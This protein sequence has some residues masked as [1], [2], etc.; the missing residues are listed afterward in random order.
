MRAHH[1]KKVLKSNLSLEKQIHKLQGGVVQEGW[2]WSI[3]DFLLGRKTSLLFRNK[4][5]IR[6]KKMFL[7]F[8]KNTLN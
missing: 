4:A 8:A 7:F 1:Y 2:R 6:E 3:T 5:I